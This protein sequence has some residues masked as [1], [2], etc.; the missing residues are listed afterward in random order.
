M[1]QASD[2]T[3]PAPALRP[4][5]DL[6]IRR[7]ATEAQAREATAAYYAAISFMDAQVGRVL[8]ALDRLKLRDN[9]IVVFFGDHGF[10][11]G[12]KGMWSKMSLY[13]VSTRVPMVIAAPGAAT[14]KVSPRTVELLD[15][16]PTLVELCGVPAPQGLQGKSLA[17]L[18]KDPAAA[19]EKPAMTVL[20]R[21]EVLGKSVR[22]ERYRYT[23]W[24]AGRQGAELYDHSADPHE[25]RNLARDPKHAKT[26]AE[27]QRLLGGT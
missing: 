11:L 4:N 17:P 14:G 7:E 21:G 16:Y 1:P 3:V 27:M 5:F 9:T 22:T 6:F 15:L 2:A 24:D 23:E 19:W 12:E 25:Q 8:D 10:H 26:V 18:L 13:E 20:K